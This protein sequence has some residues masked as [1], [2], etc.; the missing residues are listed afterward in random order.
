MDKIFRAFDT[1]NK[2]YENKGILHYWLCHVRPDTG[3]INYNKFNY[4]IEQC[5][6]KDKYKKRIFEGDVLKFLHFETNKNKHYLYHV[7]VYDDGYKAYMAI[8]MNNYR[9]GEVGLD[10]NGNMFLWTGLYR[11]EYCGVCGNINKPKKI[12]DKVN[13]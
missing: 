7:V 2:T 1:T 11:P 13:E 9:K 8:E 10:T 5:C 12:W 3:T 4:I 6:G